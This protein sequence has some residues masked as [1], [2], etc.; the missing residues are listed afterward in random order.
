LSKHYGYEAGRAE[1]G[2]QGKE[3]QKLVDESIDG[4]MRA[5]YKNGFRPCENVAIR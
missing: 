4:Q 3:M 5:N 1:K 2:T